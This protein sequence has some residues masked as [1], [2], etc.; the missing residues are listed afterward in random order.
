MTKRKA[1]IVG[2]L[3]AFYLAIV[4]IVGAIWL[5]GATYLAVGGVSSI[6]GITI[7]AVYFLVA[8]IARK[9]EST[10][11]PSPE[12]KAEPQS[13]Q[14]PI[15]ADTDF[16]TLLRTA[17]A[18]L[19]AS[20]KLKSYKVKPSILDLPLYLIVGDSASGKTSTFLQAKLEPEPLAGQIFR[21]ELIVSTPTAN[22]WFVNG[23][24][25]VEVSGSYFSADLTRWR[26]LIDTLHDKTSEPMLLKI[27]KGPAPQ[28]T[29]SGV[30]L[31]VDAS[32]FTDIPEGSQLAT[33][34]RSTQEK[35]RAVA[36]AFG[37]DYGV[38]V[39]FSKSDAI[40]NFKNYFNRATTSEDQQPLGCDLPILTAS[41]RSSTELYS[42]A[43]SKRIGDAFDDLYLSLA[44]NRLKMLPREAEMTRRLSAYEFPRN[45]KRTRSSIVQF[46]VDVFQPNQLQPGP[47]LRGFYFTGIRDAAVRS[48]QLPV[49][50]TQASSMDRGATVLLQGDELESQMERIRVEKSKPQPEY[51]EAERTQPRWCFV[52]ELFNRILNSGAGP[53][54]Q[55]Q[56]RKSGVYRQIAFSCMLAVCILLLLGIALSGWNNKKFLDSV[57]GAMVAVQERP[58]NISTASRSQLLALDNL[59][60]RLID[61]ETYDKSTPWSMRF[62]LYRGGSILE[63]ARRLYFSY[64]RDLLLSPVAKDLEVEM[65][66]LPAKHDDS[67]PY[68][69]IYSHLQSYL[70]VTDRSCPVEPGLAKALTGAWS[71]K[72]STD[73]ETSE[74]AHQQFDFYVLELERNAVPIGIDPRA[75]AVNRARNYL[76]DFGGEMRIYRSLL[77]QANQTAGQPVRFVEYAP[78]YREVLEAVEDIRPAYSR[79]GWNAM[80]DRIAAVKPEE[81]GDSCVL[82][83]TAAAILESPLAGV[84]LQNKLRVLYAAD[85]VQQWRTLLS[86]ARFRGYANGQ[87]A[88]KKLKA[89]DSD[90]ALLGL[91]YMVHENTAVSNPK[92]AESSG[93]QA[94][95]KAGQKTLS[96]SKYGAAG[97]ALATR[98]GASG[99]ETPL[100]PQEVFQPVHRLFSG[101]AKKSNWHCPENDQYS[102]A[103]GAVYRAMND[104]SQ[105]ATPDADVAL[106]TQ[107]KQA[108]EQ[109][110][111]TVTE[112][113]HAF[114]SGAIKDSTVALLNAPFEATSGHYVVD[115]AKNEKEK[116]VGSAAALCRQ[117][118]PLFRKFP[119]NPAAS[120]VEATPEEVA[121]IFS[122]QTGALWAFYN[123]SLSKYVV[124]QGK[125]YELKADALPD[126]KINGQ[127]LQNFNQLAQISNALFADG[128]AAPSTKYALTVLPNPDLKEVSLTVDGQK[129]TQGSHEFAWPGSVQGVSLALRTTDTE[130]SLPYTGP[131]A[132]FEL[133]GETD[134]H[135]PGSREVGLSKVRHGPRSQP[136]EIVVGGKAVTIKLKIDGFPGEVESAF[137]KGFFGCKCGPRILE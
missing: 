86:N 80:Q 93:L 66:G 54:A 130:I 46:L 89:L 21:D 116:L 40:P 137:D 118:T 128:S 72:A 134:P 22:I 126:I 132:I 102:K 122:P 43:E 14:R 25:V 73:R 69:T 8:R 32:Q 131:W 37:S 92:S 104:L 2:L 61:L 5:Q 28:R 39:V 109:G 117:M 74:L 106:N 87:D 33:A 58:I 50:R 94:L 77:D 17:N 107:T 136:S 79:D 105:V 12:Y 49:G 78:N 95:E 41:D 97:K 67:Y 81:L 20:Q 18:K 82:G 11:A 103:I 51:L 98:I 111:G 71:T 64:F 36:E 114:D 121:A 48:D 53:L 83:K 13:A 115:F 55:Y 129:V 113:A 88:T 16:Q 75:D 42:H 26:R 44:Q 47:L 65:K 100:D 10:Q 19:A 133:M 15:Q 125:R 70:T 6:C 31:I 4:W 112:V 52:A 27:W 34:A 135:P 127:F 38:W 23:A 90:S 85:F 119:F 59:R 91:L 1:V 3:L 99:P 101:D 24:L 29:L 110:L 124:K 120:A 45:L 108:V 63:P 30:V 60:Q 68:N 123:Q 76:R 35:L 96:Q 57:N 84:E 56:D 9:S 62:F 7:A